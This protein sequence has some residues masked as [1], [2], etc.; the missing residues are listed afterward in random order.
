MHMGAPALATRERVFSGA[1]RDRFPV[2][3][4]PQLPEPF[5]CEVVPGPGHVR[6]VPVGE[7]DL[8]TGAILDGRLR[9]LRESGAERLV[10]D[11][12]RLDFMDSSGL[13]LLLHWEELTRADGAELALVAGPP[14]IQR[15]CETTGL[16][17][18]LR[19]VEAPPDS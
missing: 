3:D 6:V 10:V 15:V 1:L 13:R 7:L 12:R 16:L 4:H 19:F 8:A 11:L 2:P 5:H 9:E 18:R 14:E 17:G